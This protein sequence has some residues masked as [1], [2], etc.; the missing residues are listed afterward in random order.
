MA[1]PRKTPAK[2][3]TAVSEPKKDYTLDNA[4]QIMVGGILYGVSEQRKDS[5]AGV[6]VFD[7]LTREGRQ[8][9][10]VVVPVAQIQLWIV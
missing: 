9:K 1:A 6:V 5:G 8:V 4:S 2:A 3:S 10:D 7:L